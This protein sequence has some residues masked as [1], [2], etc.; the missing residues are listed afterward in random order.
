M[1]FDIKSIEAEAAQ[2][3][4]QE[5]VNKAKSRIKESLRAV[6]RARV[7]YENAKAEHAVTVREA[8]EATV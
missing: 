3:L 8:G 1:S 5:R 2:E 4:N 6:E 7:I